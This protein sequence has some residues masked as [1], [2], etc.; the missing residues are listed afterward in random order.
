MRSP[1][2]LVLNLFII[3]FLWGC[4]QQDEGVLHKELQQKGITKE[5]IQEL[6]NQ[7]FQRFIQAK[8]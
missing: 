6:Q 7:A 8:N 4:D 2:I 5:Y 1:G 3:V